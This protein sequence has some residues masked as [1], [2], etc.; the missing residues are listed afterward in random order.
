MLT[1][2]K[3]TRAPSIADVVRAK[4][5]ITHRNSRGST[6]EY[7]C[8]FASHL[9]SGW[10]GGSLLIPLSQVENLGRLCEVPLAFASN[11]EEFLIEHGTGNTVRDEPNPSH[12]LSLLTLPH[13]TCGISF[14]SFSTRIFQCWKPLLRLLCVSRIFANLEIRTFLTRCWS[15]SLIDRKYPSSYLLDVLPRNWKNEFRRCNY[16]L[17][18]QRVFFIASAELENTFPFDVN[19]SASIYE[20]ANFNSSLGAKYTFYSNLCLEKLAVF[21][22]YVM[23][24]DTLWDDPAVFLNSNTAVLASR[25][26]LILDIFLLYCKLGNPL[27]PDFFSLGMLPNSWLAIALSSLRIVVLLLGYSLEDVMGPSQDSEN[28]CMNGCL[29]N[30]YQGSCSINEVIEAILE[31]FRCVQD[32]WK[33]FQRYFFQIFFEIGGLNDII[34]LYC[35]NLRIFVSEIFKNFSNVSLSLRDECERMIGLVYDKITLSK[36]TRLVRMPSLAN[37]DLVARCREF[38]EKIS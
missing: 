36:Y 31:R 5:F 30:F 13:L 7:P 1:C 16:L 27:P 35:S 21:R 15:V 11:I 3:G 17:F 37:P 4:S 14:F 12:I 34:P 29:N 23:S 8:Q 18:S 22:D 28:N 32:S 24:D 33:Q 20:T 38:F 9:L 26:D 19:V 10:I 2:W 6:F 25:T